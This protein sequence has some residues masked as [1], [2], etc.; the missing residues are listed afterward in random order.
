MEVPVVLFRPSLLPLVEGDH[1]TA[2]MLSQMIYWWSPDKHGVSKLRVQ[3]GS[4]LWLVKSHADWE[5]ELGLSRRQSDRC[6]AKLKQ[7]GLIQVEIH[8]FNGAPTTHIRLLEN[9]AYSDCTYWSIPIAP[10]G[11]NTL[12]A[13]VQSLTE[14]TA[15]TTSESTSHMNADDIL[16]SF[17]Q[18][19][20][21]ANAGPL[22]IKA[23]SLMWKKHVGCKFYRPI[24]ELDN[25]GGYADIFLLPLCDIYKDMEDSYIVELKYCKPGTSDEQLNHLFEEASAQIRRYANS[26][27]VHKSVKTTKL[28]QLVVI[29]RG[30]EMAMCEEVE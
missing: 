12:H 18:P 17:Q 16:K 8:R 26:D 3:V 11:A 21:P 13:Q 10:A 14:T 7:L 22:G 5:A 28:H 2:L 24:S 1:L 15:K 9:P 27:I 23:M 30:A 20:T 29:Y 6:L 4:R 19:A 25:D